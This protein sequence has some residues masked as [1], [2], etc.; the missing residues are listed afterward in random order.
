M[1]FAKK[2][3]YLSARRMLVFFSQEDGSTD[4]ICNIMIVKRS[5]VKGVGRSVD[6]AFEEAFDRAVF[7]VEGLRVCATS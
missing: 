7:K 4:Y 2:L 3:E 1:T 5:P 6:E